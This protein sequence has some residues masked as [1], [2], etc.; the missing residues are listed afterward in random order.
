MQSS[1]EQDLIRLTNAFLKAEGAVAV[2][3]K[4]LV[5]KL[6]M[7]CPFKVGDVVQRGENPAQFLVTKV[8]LYP[9]DAPDRGQLRGRKLR[10]DGQPGAQETWLGYMN[11]ENF[12][13]VAK[14]REPVDAS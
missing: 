9:S 12:K 8:I 7:L 10:K 13:V 6:E 3:R 14:W 5:G 2:A 11:Y 1:D 4:E